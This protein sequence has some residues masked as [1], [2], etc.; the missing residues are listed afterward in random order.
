MHRWHD[1]FHA[2]L[3]RAELVGV[4]AAVRAYLRREPTRAEMNA[5]RRAVHSFAVAEPADIYHVMVNGK[6]MLLLARPGVEV[7]TTVAERA[8]TRRIRPD[9]PR[10]PDVRRLLRTVERGIETAATAARQ[11][12][13]ADID[14]PHA[15][16]AAAVLQQA[17]SE[18]NT[19]R[20]RLTRR[21]QG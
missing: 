6:Q 5:A 18:L 9:Q 14:P 21:G 3:T 12:N 10:T 15:D 20:R 7:D 19:F 17:I 4:Q 8:V 16:E 13:V 1:V 2:A 11:I